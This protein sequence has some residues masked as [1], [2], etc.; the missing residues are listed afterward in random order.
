[1]ETI[2]FTAT[3]NYSEKGIVTPPIQFAHS[4][5]ESIMRNH[6]HGYPGFPWVVEHQGFLP[7]Y[8]ALSPLSSVQLPYISVF[9]PSHHI[10]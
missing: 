8:Q 4:T 1:M 6:L 3:P 9:Y 5:G 2:I 10:V 7:N